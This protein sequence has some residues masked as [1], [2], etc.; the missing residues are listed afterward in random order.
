VLT[1]VYKA[2]LVYVDSKV[3]VLHTWGRCFKLP[4]AS[5]HIGGSAIDSI[6]QDD[7]KSYSFIWLSLPHGRLVEAEVK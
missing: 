2:A 1:Q 3:F 4:Y 5:V 6:E 7:P